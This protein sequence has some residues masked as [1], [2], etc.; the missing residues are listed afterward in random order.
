M[1]PEEQRGLIS[2][3]KN[4]IYKKAPPPVN[5]VSFNPRSLWDKTVQSHQE[6]FKTNRDRMAGL[7]HLRNLLARSIPW[8]STDSNSPA[9]TTT[10]F[11]DDNIHLADEKEKEKKTYGQSDRVLRSTNPSSEDEGEVSPQETPGGASPQETPVEREAETPP[12]AGSGS[13]PTED[14]IQ[15]APLPQIPGSSRDLQVPMVTGRSEAD[16]TIQDGNTDLNSDHPS[17]Q[18]SNIA[19]SN[20]NGK[21]KKSR[22]RKSNAADGAPGVNK[23][24]NN[25]KEFKLKTDIEADLK[26]ANTLIAS[27]KVQ[28]AMM[29]ERTD[30]LIKHGEEQYRLIL[31]LERKVLRATAEPGS[32]ESLIT[33][34][35]ILFTRTADRDL[36]FLKHAL[37]E[38]KASISDISKTLQTNNIRVSDHDNGTTDNSATATEVRTEETPPAQTPL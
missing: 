19:A 13:P 7:G 31:S 33:E 24:R 21:G 27:Q 32:R 37:M 9:K 16:S 15:I 18:S 10:A 11:Q 3:F 6:R 26:A 1:D 36:L 2:H 20:P 5:P 17:N 29:Q 30:G 25:N 22:K 4:F 35:D 14:Q 8:S 38:C 34:P 28:L 23:G 12:G